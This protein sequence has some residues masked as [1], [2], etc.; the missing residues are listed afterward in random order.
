MVNELHNSLNLDW[1]V[2]LNLEGY[3]KRNSK[4]LILFSIF[5]QKKS[6][7]HMRFARLVIYVLIFLRIIKQS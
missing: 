3:S 7:W 5:N 2:P 1:D 4:S 6:E